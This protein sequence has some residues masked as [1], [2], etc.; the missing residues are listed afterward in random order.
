MSI[1]VHCPVCGYRIKAPDGSYGRRGVCPRCKLM[2][3]LPKEEDAA[4]LENRPLG[5]AA[6][7]GSPDESRLDLDIDASP[8]EP[9]QGST[10]RTKESGSALEFHAGSQGM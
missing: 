8:P 10:E 5:E 3:R 1:R 7:G 6:S 2:I 4:A 9:K